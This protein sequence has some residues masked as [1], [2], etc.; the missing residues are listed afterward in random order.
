MNALS[1]FLENLGNMLMPPILLSCGL[2]FAFFSFLGYFFSLLFFLSSL[3]L[4]P[5]HTHAHPLTFCILIFTLNLSSSNI[6]KQNSN[7]LRHLPIA[8]PAFFALVPPSSCT[9]TNDRSIYN[10]ADVCRLYPGT[11]THLCLV[12]STGSLLG[13]CL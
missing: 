10:P 12:I 5:I 13:V 11:G 9:R 7:T 1:P 6:Y 3:S 2:V 8:R 4:N